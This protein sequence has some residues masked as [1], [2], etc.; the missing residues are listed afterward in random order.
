MQAAL[1]SLSRPAARA[2]FSCGFFKPVDTAE[3]ISGI[4]ALASAAGRVVP[5]RSRVPPKAALEIT[6]S[7]ARRIVDL[8]QGRQDQEAAIAVRLGVRTRGCNGLS[9]TMNYATSK[10]KLEE[11]VERDG[12]RVFVEPKALMH[13]IG[14]TMDFIEDELTSE[15]IFHNP[16]AEASCGCGESFTVGNS[17]Q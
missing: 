14:T 5:R 8:L 10:A 9:Y 7:A 4:R 6:D 16:N 11:E 2:R 12:A 13:V 17:T 15:F 3:G 1:G